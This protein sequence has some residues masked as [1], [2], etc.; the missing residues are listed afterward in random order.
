MPAN[1]FDFTWLVNS[2]SNVFMI[3]GF[4]E[5]FVQYDVFL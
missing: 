1:K 3:F 4:D 2:A 5:D